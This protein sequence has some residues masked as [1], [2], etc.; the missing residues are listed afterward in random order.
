MLK[1]E[2]MLL[3]GALALAVVACSGSSAQM[4]Q[5]HVE[6]QHEGKPITDV[7]IIAMIEDQEI[8]AIL[9]KHF[10]DWLNVKGVEA[11]ISADVLPVKVGTKL[12]KEA[13]LKVLEEHENDTILITRVVGFGETEVF[14][15]SRP[16][17]FFN[18]YGYYNYALG[19]IYWPTV[20]GEKVQLSLETAL[21]DVKTES[22]IWAGVSQL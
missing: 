6:A 4:V 10:K 15:R 11:M 14:S 19:Y 7:L 13:I 3:M 22:P 17:V 2:T 18:Y 1:I 9:E 20:Y 8:R 12:E 5:T 21:Y 16:Q